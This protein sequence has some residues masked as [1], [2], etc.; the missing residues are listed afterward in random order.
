MSVKQTGDLM[1]IL[2]A[3]TFTFCSGMM[4]GRMI[5]IDKCAAYTKGPPAQRVIMEVV[6][7]P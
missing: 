6:K 7:R 4:I 2:A 3:L 5:E 1:M